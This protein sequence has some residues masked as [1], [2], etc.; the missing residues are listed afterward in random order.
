[1][2]KVRVDLQKNSY[3]IY[4][5]S[6]LLP[7]V[8][9]W[10]KETGL[11][12]KAVI[13]TD[14]TVKG[15][16][17][18]VLSRGLTGAG[19]SVTVLDI[20]PGEEHKTLEAAGGFYE[21][22]TGVYAERIT[23]IIALGGGVIGDLA[24]FVAATYMRGVPLVQVPTTLLAQVDSS[25]G[26]KTAVD[27]GRLKNMIGAFYQPRM[28]VADVDTLKTLPDVEFANGMAE[29]IKMAAIMSKD[30][31]DYIEKN[32]GKA[33][34]LDTAVLEEIIS[35]N[36]RLKAKVVAKDE[37]ESD[38][39]AILN[40][41]HTVGHAVEAVSA[42]GLKHGQAVAIGMVAEA[43]IS[44][45]IGKMKES[46]VVRLKEVIGKAGLP[47]DIPTLNINEVMTA[48]RH[49]K[50]VTGD[51]IRFVLLNAIGD[52]YITDGVNP[53]LVEEVLAGHG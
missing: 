40:F 49:D 7:Q 48:M 38:L 2:K 23:P 50:K 35:A 8:G 31:F 36:A 47:V 37:K 15:L 28:V 22:L 6:G 39:R 25:I 14:T 20:P 32:I 34:A 3:E 30:L 42:F 4:I 53:A 17:A 9:P 33:R 26:G 29:A 43:R 24:G 16:Y 41:G 44:N 18:D 46:D 10:L 51:K 19:F 13:V 11:S 52:A 12:G 21:K 27:Y 1:M 5:G 45:R